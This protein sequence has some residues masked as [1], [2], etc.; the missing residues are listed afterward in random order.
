MQGNSRYVSES[1]G[2]LGSNSLK[3]ISS[4]RI[5]VLIGHYEACP[6]CFIWEEQ[7]R[8]RIMALYMH[9]HLL[10]RFLTLYPRK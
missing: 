7:E 6:I 10:Q 2:E 1:D 5:N 4:V 9:L 3:L 8:E